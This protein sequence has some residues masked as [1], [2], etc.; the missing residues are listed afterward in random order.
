MRVEEAPQALLGEGIDGVE[1]LRRG[2]C[3]ELDQLV[4]LLEADERI[5]EPMRCLADRGCGQVGSELTLRGKQEVH[6]GSGDR[7][8]DEEEPT[9]E[10]STDPGQLDQRRSEHYRRRLQEDVAM[11]D[12]RELVSDQAL[13]LGGDAYPQ[14]AGTD[15]EP[16]AVWPAA[17][18]ERTGM[19][20]RKQMELR[21]GYSRASRQTLDRGME[22]RGLAERQLPRS[23]HPE[24][25]SISEPIHGARR[26]ECAKHQ[27]GE[28]VES[29]DCPSEGSE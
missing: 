22:S 17:G 3:L 28:Q 11:P 16:G 10:P 14:Q 8:Q 13:E 6:E 23:D 1:R 27:D 25:D 4:R 26:Q 12:V 21:F 5:G 19:S 15:R 9:L 20:V 29:T 2:T 7:T 18:H 24:R